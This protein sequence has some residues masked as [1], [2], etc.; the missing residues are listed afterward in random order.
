MKVSGYFRTSRNLTSLSIPV[1]TGVYTL[2]LSLMLL[3]DLTTLP[4]TEVPVI[5]GILIPWEP[6]PKPKLPL[7]PAR[8]QH[9]CLSLSAT[10]SAFAPVVTVGVTYSIKSSRYQLK[11]DTLV[12]T[13]IDF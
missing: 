3:A 2:F 1:V 4:T 5:Q 10:Y 12:F 7:A 13:K 11:P 8:Q 6:E 9:H